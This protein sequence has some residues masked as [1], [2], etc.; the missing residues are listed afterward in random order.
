MSNY[1]S[2]CKYNQ[3][4][5]TGDKACPFNFFYW[6]FLNRHRDRLQSLGRMNLVLSHFK[7]MSETEL[8][9]ISSLAAEWWEN[10]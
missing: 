4:D 7:R 10:Q 6:D 2:D 1:C 3:S 9:Q 8:D 5:R